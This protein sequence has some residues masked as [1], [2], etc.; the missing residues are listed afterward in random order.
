MM[1]NKIKERLPKINFVLGAALF[2]LSSFSFYGDGQNIQAIIFL[3]LGLGNLALVRFSEGTTLWVNLL[4]L[5]FNVAGAVV[6]ALD[7][8]SKGTTGLHLV[9]WLIAI[10]YTVSIGVQIWKN[11]QPDTPTKSE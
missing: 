6:V 8:Q 7:Y 3:L 10:L 2:L 4:V 5:A 9:W 1:R 11:K